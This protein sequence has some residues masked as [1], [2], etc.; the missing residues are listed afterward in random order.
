[1]TDIAVLLEEKKRELLE[2]EEELIAQ[3]GML[4][5]SLNELDRYNQSLIAALDKVKESNSELEQL[6][7]QSSHGLRS[8]LTSI[9]GII[10]L[11]E[12]EP[13]SPKSEEYRKHIKG[14]VSHMEEI[15]NS[16]TTFSRLVTDEVHQEMTAMDEIVLNSISYFGPLAK[17]NKVKFQFKSEL[18]STMIRTDPFLINAFF[19]QIVMN[20][21][22]F[23]NSSK[24]GMVLI[25]LFQDEKTMVIVVEDDGDG[26]D[27]ALGDKIFKMFFRGSE[28]S[29]GSGLG[30][31]IA[32]KAI[33]LLNGSVGFR[34]RLGQ[35]I[36]EV[37]IPVGIPPSVKP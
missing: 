26:I 30:L 5:L 35:T 22:V 36:F 19:K 21:L 27:P 29:A 2:K 15:L 12:Y 6:L 4:M 28:K 34:S 17:Q 10:N 31:F 14:K 20:A 7:Y 25:R 16:L 24:D 32:K 37:R 11:L 9:K 33:E 13:L 8:P 3:L 23:R 18:G 1:M